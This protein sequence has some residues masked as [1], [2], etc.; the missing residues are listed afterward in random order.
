MKLLRYGPRARTSRHTRTDAGF[1]RHGQ[2]RVRAALADRAAR[3]N[4]ARARASIHFTRSARGW[5]VRASRE[6]GSLALT[7]DRIG[8]EY[9][10][11]VLTR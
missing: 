4:G 6:T 9:H 7:L 2:R 10:L 11:A 5:R 8:I 1:L 3:V